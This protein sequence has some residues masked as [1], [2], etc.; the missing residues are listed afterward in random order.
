MH[1]L[2]LPRQETVF[3]RMPGNCCPNNSCAAVA[4]ESGVFVERNS[5]SICPLM[6][7]GLLLKHLFNPINQADR[8]AKSRPL[9]PFQF[10]LLLPQ[11]LFQTWFRSLKILAKMYSNKFGQGFLG[12]TIALVQKTNLHIPEP[13]NDVRVGHTTHFLFG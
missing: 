3:V 2:K 1:E 5:A 11:V 6:F 7:L 12:S 13:T 4:G 8:G 10:A 9:F